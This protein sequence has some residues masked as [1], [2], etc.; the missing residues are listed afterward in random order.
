MQIYYNREELSKTTL[1]KLNSANVFYQKGYFE[2]INKTDKIPAY[3]ADDDEII[4]VAF[5]KKIF[6]CYVQLPT[7]PYTLI[8]NN[9]GTTVFL[10]KVMTL[11]REKGVMWVQHPN[12]AAVFFDTPT[13]CIQIPFGN[14]V[15]NLKRELDEIFAGLHSKHRNSVRRALKSEVVIKYGSEETLLNEFY[16]MVKITNAR[17]NIL[18]QTINYYKKEINLINSIIFI[19]YKDNFP[20]GGAILF[21]N[22]QRSY[23]I[24]GATID[25]P[26]PGSMNLLHWEA[27]KYMKS[28][29][30]AYY[31][32][33]GARVNEDKNSK[34]HGIQ[35]FKKRFGGELESIFLFKVIFKPYFY[36]LFNLIMKIRS[37]LKKSRY[38]GDIIDQE[39]HKWK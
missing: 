36:N 4:L 18:N 29:K 8:D 21:Y 1:L 22:N 28:Q 14:Y 9:L 34:F 27:I 39:Y 32:F 31:S 11:L 37:I 26:E 16:D 25:N 7:E 12:A 13:D 35:E 30:V 33:V 23:Y 3:I 2:Y 17:S 10:D 20:Q 19:A 5:V 6:F 15:I 38:F 24:H